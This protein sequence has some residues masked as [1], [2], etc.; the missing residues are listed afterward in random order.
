MS[1]K[2]RFDVSKEEAK[3]IA[4]I[5]RRVAKIAKEHGIRINQIDT[6]MDITATHM[7]GCKLRLVDMWAADEFNLMHDVMGIRD[8]INRKTGKLGRYFLPRFADCGGEC[9][10]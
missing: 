2:I 3:I 6:R 8:H 1:K 9:A 7:N 10:A 5:A 4:S